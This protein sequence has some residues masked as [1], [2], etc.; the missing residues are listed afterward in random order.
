M[1]QMFISKRTIPKSMKLISSIDSYFNSAILLRELRLDENDV[2]FMRLIDKSEISKDDG[3]INTPF[4][5]YIPIFNMSTGLKTL[6]LVNHS[7]ES[8]VIDISQCG[9][10]VINILFNYMDNKR[11]YTSFCIVPYELKIPIRIN[12]RKDTCKD[13]SDLLTVWEKR[14]GI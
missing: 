2:K 14:Y 5:N 8:D 4:G 1:N 12:N 13:T 7:K 9:Y 10:N 6:I 11:Y 3:Y